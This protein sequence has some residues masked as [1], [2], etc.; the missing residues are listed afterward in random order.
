MRY[1]V[2]IIGF[3]LIT[4]ATLLFIISLNFNTISFVSHKYVLD[5]NIQKIITLVILLIYLFPTFIITGALFTILTNI[6]IS[7]RNSFLLN[8]GKLLFI[9]DK[10][11]TNI[12]ISNK[13][14]SKFVFVKNYFIIL[15][16]FIFI[17]LICI[18]ISLYYNIGPKIVITSQLFFSE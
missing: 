8:N 7:L 12:K 15:N 3:I 9:Y 13:I 2:A 1:T 11:Y 14:I 17:I 10:Q 4:I 6:M 18:L 5:I 16:I